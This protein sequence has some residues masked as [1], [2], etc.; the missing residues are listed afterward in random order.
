MLL[1]LPR[2]IE[3][4]VDAE[5]RR[6][7]ARREL[8]EGLEEH[9][10]QSLGR[11]EEE[12]AVGSPLL[13][14]HGRVFAGPL[15]RVTPQVEERR[16]TQPNERLLPDSEAV[17]ALLHEVDL[18]VLVAQRHQVAVV[19]PVEEALAGI[20]SYLPLQERQQVV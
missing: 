17:R 4:L 3:R 2:L 7:L 8:L 11:H 1:I 20:V 16:E 15:E 19:A 14:E 9:A 13:V 18:P 6:L 12:H 10:D 5:A